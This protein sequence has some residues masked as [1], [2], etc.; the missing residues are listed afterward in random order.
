MQI[1]SLLT[2]QKLLLVHG[3]VMRWVMRRLKSST[4]LLWSIM[5]IL[6]DSHGMFRVS[7]LLKGAYTK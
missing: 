5:L 2:T 1:S 4:D 7:K 6:N 3:T